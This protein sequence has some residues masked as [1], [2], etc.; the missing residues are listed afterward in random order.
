MSKLKTTVG[1]VIELL[2]NF[3]DDA[4]V[5]IEEGDLIVIENGTRFRLDIENEIIREG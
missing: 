1:D 2:D 5:E 3:N 4:T